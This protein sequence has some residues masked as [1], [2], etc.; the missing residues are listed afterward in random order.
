MQNYGGISRCFAAFIP[1]LPRIFRYKIAINYSNNV[2]LVENGLL[3]SFEKYK[4]KYASFLG[5]YK[6]KGKGKLF[7]F[8][9]SLFYP[10]EASNKESNEEYSVR[11][12]KNGDFDVFHPTYFD[13][14][15][16][17]HLG[18]K[19]FVLTIHDMI[20]ELFPEYFNRDDFQIVKKHKLI[21]KAAH[22]VAVSEN[23]KRDIID[24][25]GVD[26]SKITVIYHGAPKTVKN[27]SHK[28]SF[29]YLL[30]VGD[31]FGYKNFIPFITVCKNIIEDNP[32]IKIVCTG[33]SF[34]DDEKNF[35]SK[36][37]ISDNIVHAFVSSNDLY[38]IYTDA[39]AF[40]Y[41]SLYEGFGIPILEA[42]ACGCPV[43]LNN[44]SCFPEV[45]G[46]SAIYFEMNDLYSNFYEIFTNFLTWSEPERDKLIEKG[47]KRLK[48]FSWEKAANQYA[49]IYRRII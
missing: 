7:R 28:S 41:P 33:K 43:F 40:V 12:L 32:K 19:P 13:D 44:K 29:P 6:F 15:F 31:R 36:L 34:N 22:I 49:D 14:Y 1:H 8:W 42:F 38:S 48:M 11:L 27:E 4:Q 47:Y 2:N 3:S 25:L 30:Y 24:I 5:G 35:F 16:L 39:L 17:D 26:P 23:T 21:K 9:Y 37:G 20:P 46:D 45:A 10:K 18:N